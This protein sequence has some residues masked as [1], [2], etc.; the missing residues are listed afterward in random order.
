MNYIPTRWW[1][2][3]EFYRSN[4]NDD[5]ETDENNSTNISDNNNRTIMERYNLN[6]SR[7]DAWVP[8][9]PISLAE[10]E[11]QEKL[12]EKR[13]NDEFEKANPEFCSQVIKQLYFN[14]SY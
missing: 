9:D 6:Y 4:V 5:E 3:A 7:W 2:G 12:E 13:K 11:E 10:K 8:S 1:L 14:L